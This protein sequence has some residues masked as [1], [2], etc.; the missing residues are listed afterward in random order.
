MNKKNK[1]LFLIEYSQYDSVN[2]EALVKILKLLNFHLHIDLLISV[3]STLV[4]PGIPVGL[5]AFYDQQLKEELVTGGKNVITKIKNKC[6]NFGVTC[7]GNVSIGSLLNYSVET[8]N[9]YDL[10]IMS[11]KIEKSGLIDEISGSIYGKISKKHN[12]P[13]WVTKSLSIPFQSLYYFN[14]TN[15]DKN[16][17]IDIIKQLQAALKIPYRKTVSEKF[18]IEK[19]LV[20]EVDNPETSF[21]HPSIMVFDSACFE[22]CPFLDKIY[23]CIEKLIKISQHHIIFLP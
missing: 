17:N 15:K 21:E 23:H 12:M 9:G 19:I 20:K 7:N 5:V 1:I 22:G 2:I 11:D 10:I 8:L 18:V 13:V 6:D 4:M 16:G 3:Q 14:L